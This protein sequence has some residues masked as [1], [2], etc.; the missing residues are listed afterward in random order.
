MG[1][2]LASS[3]VG[4]NASAIERYT[5]F[6]EFLHT[7]SLIIDDI[8]VAASGVRAGRWCACGNG[9]QGTALNISNAGRSG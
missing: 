9:R 1:L 2:L 8:Q 6:P 3:V 7:G 4:G 5:S